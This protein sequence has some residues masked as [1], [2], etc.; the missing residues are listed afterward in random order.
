VV[1]ANELRPREVRVLR[2]RTGRGQEEAER[3][4]VVAAQEVADRDR[5]A[6]ADAEL[7]ALHRQELARDDIV[8]QLQRL[9]GSELAALPVSEEDAR[10]DHRVEDDVVLAHEVEVA[11]LWVLP[12][13]APGLWRSAIDRPLDS[14]REVADDSVEPDIDPLVVALGVVRRHR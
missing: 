2:L 11:R 12:T 1:P 7:L 5:D 10:P 3:I 4:R 14:G 13:V 6:A 8:R 9:A